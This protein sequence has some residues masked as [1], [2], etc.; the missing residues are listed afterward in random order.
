M[1]NDFDAAVA[2]TM[3]PDQGQA[4]RLGFAAAQDTNP[5]AYAEAQRVARRTGVPV[6]TV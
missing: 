5:D 3:Q 6:D 1:S 2:A 4:A